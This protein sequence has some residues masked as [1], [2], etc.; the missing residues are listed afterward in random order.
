MHLY[1][2]L[3]FT[4]GFLKERLL[5]RKIPLLVSWLLTNRCNY[6]CKYCSIWN[7]QTKELNFNQARYII[8]ELSKCGTKVISFSG[9]EPLLR[10]DIGR[11]IDYCSQKGIYTKLT[12]NGS[13]VAKKIDEIKN[14]N[15]VKLSFDGPSEVHDLH[16]QPGSYRNVIDAAR[17][18]KEYNINVIFN[19][20]ISKLN[21]GYLDYILRNAEQLNIKVTFQ[22]LEYRD[23]K[24]FAALNTPSETQ[25]KEAIR[26]L[27]SKKKRGYK[28]IANSLVGLRYMYNWPNYKKMKCWAGIFHFRLTPDGRLLTCDRLP[29]FYD[30]FNCLEKNFKTA[31]ET[32]QPPQCVEGC[33]RNT[34][35]ELN[36]LLSLRPLSILNSI[37]IF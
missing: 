33:W 12:T 25:F 29:T 37:G 31:F 35:I 24:D 9:G 7:K 32:L 6:Q 11:I 16:R 14:V 23:N 22:P 36:C 4:I 10:E 27:I 2:K 21:I 17:L 13:L 19:C 26:T 34:T 28:Y 1:Q 30:S 15:V 8:N 18:L 20:V 5:E 3:F